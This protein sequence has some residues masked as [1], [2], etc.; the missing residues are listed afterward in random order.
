MIL[1]DKPNCPIPQRI[2]LMRKKTVLPKYLNPNDFCRSK[3]I[4]NHSLND[5][6]YTVNI[7]EKKTVIL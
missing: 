1:N 5:H 3:S 2:T 4:T 6:N 7:D